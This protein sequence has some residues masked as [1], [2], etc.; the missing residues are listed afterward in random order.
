[1]K[2]IYCPECGDVVCLTSD[3]RSCQCGNCWGQYTDAVNAM[4]SENA[5]VL[6]FANSSFTNALKN[7]PTDPNGPGKEFDAFIIPNGCAT[8][9]RVS[10]ATV[11][12]Q[13]EY[14]KFSLHLTGNPREYELPNGRS[15]HISCIKVIRELTRLG[16]KEAKAIVD[17]CIAT[18]GATIKNKLTETEALGWAAKFKEESGATTEVIKDE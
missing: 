2:L 10:M 14:R 15:G 5:V 1:M 17:E 12:K 16:L 13:F 9:K 11:A 3:P 7:P 4:V 6:G 18:G 8:V